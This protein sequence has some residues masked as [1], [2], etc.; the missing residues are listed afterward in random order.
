MVTLSSNAVAGWPVVTRTSTKPSEGVE[1]GELDGVGVLVAVR[2]AVADADVEPDADADAEDVSVSECVLVLDAAL[3]RDCVAENATLYV[4]VAVTV[5]VLVVVGE[6]DTSGNAVAVDVA[7][8][9]RRGGALAVTMAVAAA[10]PVGDPDDDEELDDDGVADDEPSAE[11]DKDGPGDTVAD[12]VAADDPELVGVFEPWAL[13]VLEAERSGVALE[14]EVNVEEWVGDRVAEAVGVRMDDN[15]ELVDGVLVKDGAFVRRAV[16]DAV[17]HDDL[18]GKLVAVKD[19]TAVT[20][21][22]GVDVVDGERDTT[23][24]NVED[25]VSRGDTD[26]DPEELSDLVGRAEREGVLVALG[27]P[28]LDWGA[29]VVKLAEGLLTEETVAAAESVA[30]EDIVGTVVDEKLVCVLRVTVAEPVVTLE[31]DTVAEGEY[32]TNVEGVAVEDAVDASV[33][34]ALAV[35]DFVK[36]EVMEAAADCDEDAVED[37]ED[38]ALAETLGEPVGVAVP[39]DEGDTVGEPVEDA[40]ALLDRERSAEGVTRDDQDV[41]CVTEGEGVFTLVP[42]CV[43]DAVPH[44]D[45]DELREPACDAVEA[46]DALDDKLLDT[47]PVEVPDLRALAELDGQPVLVTVADEL[48]EARKETELVPEAEGDPTDEVLRRIDPD[49]EGDAEGDGVLLEDV[50]ERGVTDGDADW[51]VEG[52]IVPD[53]VKLET[54]EGVTIEVPVELALTVARVLR[55]GLLD[56]DDDNVDVNVGLFV[57]VT[58]AV[59]M[60]DMED[61]V[62]IVTETHPLAVTTGEELMLTVTVMV[63]DAVRVVEPLLEAVR[64][65]D[66]VVQPEG[67]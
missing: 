40:H 20:E 5:S 63:P 59:V 19:L 4:R 33:S 56:T 3:V 25:R 52:D 8:M 1:E 17:V 39:E 2:V 64:V 61:D 54:A 11:K 44:M 48:P 23:G 57:M 45:A 60:T 9:D 31:A 36:D 28:V 22:T 67:L 13:L 10:D 37:A 51:H 43:G 12:A 50:E 15:D 18:V 26:E 14:V 7:E 29:L 58:E 41:L 34:V 21:D 65:T 55:D 35:G 24:V 38:V 27:D 30:L 46:A 47:E 42:V 32:V 53:G 62:V 6:G 16:I 49:E 66:T